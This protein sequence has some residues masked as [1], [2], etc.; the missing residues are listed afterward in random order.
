MGLTLIFVKSSKLAKVKMDVEAAMEGE[1]HSEPT[2]QFSTQKKCFTI[3][4]VSE[5]R[6]RRTAPSEVSTIVYL[7]KSNKLGTRFFMGKYGKSMG[8]LKEKHLY[9]GVVM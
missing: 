5:F 2:Q 7:S 8:L 3:P 4:A 9:L 6:C 1:L